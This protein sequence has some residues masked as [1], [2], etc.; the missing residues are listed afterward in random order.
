MPTT[1]FAATQMSG[2]P[3]LPGL[4]AASVWIRS[5]RMTVALSWMR[6]PFAETTPWVTVFWNSPSGLPMATTVAPTGAF[7]ESAS[8]AATSPCAGTL[9]TA[10]SVCGS[11]PTS[12]AFTVRLSKKTTSNDAPTPPRPFSTTWLFVAM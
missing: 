12:V 9:S 6:R 10:I 4:M 1:C 3:E 7:S 11:R 5:S 2:P 8:A